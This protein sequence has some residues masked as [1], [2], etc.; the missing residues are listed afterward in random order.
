MSEATTAGERLRNERTRL[1]YN[2]RDFAK[3]GGVGIGTQSSYENDKSQPNA[4]YLNKIS[5][6][7]AEIFWIMRGELEDDE[8][9]DKRNAAYTPDIRAFI[10]DYELCS[11]TVQNSL[12]EIAK[13]AADKKRAM[14]K[15]WNEA[16][17][18]EAKK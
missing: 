14:V 17:R 18:A 3:V 5:A 8:M 16:Q 15:E 13:D 11:E 1:G 2:I 10:T 6:I 9:R 4:E 12:R 7:G